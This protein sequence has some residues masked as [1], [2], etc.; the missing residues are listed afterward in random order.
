MKTKWTHSDIASQAG[1]TVL[2]TG[3]NSGTGFETAREFAGKNAKVVMAVRNLEKGNDAAAKIK[4]D[5]PKADVTVMK[6]DLS[7]LASVRNFAN[8]FNAKHDKLDI[9]INNAGV[10]VPPYS[11]TEDG[12]EL[13]FGTNHLGHFA[14]TGLL[15]DLLLKTENS[16]VVTMSSMAHKGGKVNFDDLHREKKYKKMETYGQSKVANLFFTYELQRKLEA[17]GSKTIAVA[18]H[19]GWAVTNLS[20]N[21]KLF[22]IA[23]PIFGQNALQGA[24]PLLYAATASDVKGGDYYG[25]EGFMEIKGHPKKVRS[26]SYSQNL[27]IANQLWEKSVELTGVKFEALEK[28]KSKA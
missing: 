11:K 13:Q 28:K 3:A 22:E 2:I 15:L 18:A 8:D 5:F 12:F 9:L 24:W 7:S 19:P 6:L 10:M 26:N 20:Q 4:K 1:K 27:Q 23:A 25:P 21:H 17:I 16:R 14:L